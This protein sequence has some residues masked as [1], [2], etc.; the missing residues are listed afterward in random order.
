MLELYE[1]LE[2]TRAGNWIIELAFK[3]DL[4]KG[5][6][7]EDTRAM[8]KICQRV[9]NPISKESASFIAHLVSAGVQGH[10]PKTIVD[11]STKLNSYFPQAVH[12]IILC[13]FA[14]PQWI[15]LV[16]FRKPLVLDIRH[17]ALEVRTGP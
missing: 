3:T 1:C 14:H 7:L 15:L 13:L 11:P 2:D 12:Q 9:S 17:F 6:A 10:Y 8:G 5:V 16:P 4:I